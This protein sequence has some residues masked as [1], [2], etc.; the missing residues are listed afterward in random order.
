MMKLRMTMNGNDGVHD[1]LVLQTL[2]ASCLSPSRPLSI[3]RD[4]PCCMQKCFDTS[5]VQPGFKRE[6]DLGFIVGGRIWVLGMQVLW[7]AMHWAYRRRF[8]A[9]GMLVF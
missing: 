7:G 6:W 5:T 2:Q 9:S 1:T 8:S 4:W 3:D